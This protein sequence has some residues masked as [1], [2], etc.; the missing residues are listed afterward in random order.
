[1]EIGPYSIIHKNV[2]IGKG[3]KIYSSV[4]IT[5]WTTIG[6]NNEFYK[7]A[8]IGEVPQ[9][10]KYKGEE[11]YLEIGDNNLIREFVT[12]HRASDA[13]GK[14]IIGNDNLIMN[15]AHIAHNCHLGNQITMAGYVGLA[16]HVIV[17]DQV[18][19][20][21]MCGIHQ[22]VRIGKLAMVGGYSK[23]LQD[24]P[25]FSL[26]EGMPVRIL[27][28]NVHGMRR[29]NVPS[30][31]RKA[32]KKALDIL[33]SRKYKRR[34]VP[35]VIRETVEMTPEVEH[36]IEFISNSSRKGLLM[37]SPHR[38]PARNKE[39]VSSIGSIE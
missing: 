26:V 15:C 37:Q 33:V 38:N 1:M 30:E 7:G 31:S 28:L 19:F 18:V 16:G 20:G 23:I 24:I 29:R 13:G 11:S 27:G 14:T 3:T 2:K 36:F 21:G 10:M 32:L 34:D 8:V 5:G 4:L 9:D 12:I 35:D 25:P 39:T 17:E 6:E 22:F